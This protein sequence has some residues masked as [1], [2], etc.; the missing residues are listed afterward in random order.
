MEVHLHSS[1][2]LKLFSPYVWMKLQVGSDCSNL[3][4]RLRQSLFAFTS[5]CF[6]QPG[7]FRMEGWDRLGQLGP[8]VHLGLGL[9]SA[10][11]VRHTWDVSGDLRSLCRFT[12]HQGSLGRICSMGVL[13]TLCFCSGHLSSGSYMS[14]RGWTAPGHK[15]NPLR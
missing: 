15:V 8:G 13:S 12:G 7:L 4:E 14:V 9:C 3:Q 11:F 1:K 6:G 5:S 10:C 2:A